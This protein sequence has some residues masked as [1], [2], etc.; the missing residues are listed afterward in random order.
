MEAAAVLFPMAEDTAGE[1]PGWEIKK[2]SVE[3][4]HDCHAL[5]ASRSSEI[6]RFLAHRIQATHRGA[7]EALVAAC[8]HAE[9]L[10]DILL[11]GEEDFDERYGRLRALRARQWG[12]TT[13]FDLL[14]RGAAL[15]IADRPYRPKRAYLE[16]SRGR[17][18]ASGFK[19]VW[20]E[21]VTPQTA[22]WCEHVL[23]WWSENWMSV[24]GSVGVAWQGEPYVPA[25][26]ENALCIYQERQ[27]RGW[28][29]PAP[30]RRTRCESSAD[31]NRQRGSKC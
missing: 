22:A 3:A 24:A 11:N 17:G 9:T 20:G 4:S 25:D 10:H 27:A 7:K 15:D 5:V 6:G 19:M 1:R 23:A 21:A 13:C 18:P 12:R 31:H 8:Q 29:G 2:V 28:V 26:L 30:H 16:G 14:L